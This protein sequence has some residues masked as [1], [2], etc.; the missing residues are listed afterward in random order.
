MKTGIQ[1]HEDY[2]K[3]NGHIPFRQVQGSVPGRSRPDFC[4]RRSAIF[5]LLSDSGKFIEKFTRIFCIV[6]VSLSI[7]GSSVFPASRPYEV[8]LDKVIA[9]VNNKPV[10][11]ADYHLYLKLSGE[12]VLD[13][14]VSEEILKRLLEEK[15]I[16]DDALKKGIGASREEIET[17]IAEFVALNGITEEELESYLQEDG[18][19]MEDYRGMVEEQIMIAKHIS[20]YVETRV[21][22][23]DD[24]IEKFYNDQ[25]EQFLKCPEKVE[26]KAIFLKLKDRASVTEITDLKRRALKIV[27][28]LQGGESFDTLLYIYSD[29]PLRSLDGKLGT[30]E[31]ETL[32]PPLDKAAFSLKEGEISGPI[33]VQDGIYFLKVV[34][35][36]ERSYRSIEEAREDIYNAIFEKKREKIYNEWIKSLWEQAS[37]NITKG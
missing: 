17:G 7:M 24:E 29:E 20:F 37:V 32:V 13:E 26:L 23:R 11:L 25:R 28:L 5:T 19:H 18:I 35:S 30:F 1:M 14:V 21:V 3:E 9:T 8:T 6:S 12:P 31:R 10:T 33:S 16:V 15:I 22:I 2:D 27:S 4:R 34:K 36:T